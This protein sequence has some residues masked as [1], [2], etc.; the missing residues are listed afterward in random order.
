VTQNLLPSPGLGTV[1]PN[2]PDPILF[3]IYR[4]LQKPHHREADA[5]LNLTAN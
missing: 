1:K 5:K 3:T 4:D 2:Y